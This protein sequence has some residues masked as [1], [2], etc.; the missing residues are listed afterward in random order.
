VRAMSE[1]LLQQF[2]SG[3]LILQGLLQFRPISR[4]HNLMNKSDC[5]PAIR[6]FDAL[7]A[8]SH[9]ST[10]LAYRRAW[11]ALQPNARFVSNAR[12]AS[13]PRLVSNARFVSKIRIRA[14]LQRCRNCCKITGAFRRCGSQY[15]LI[16][17]RASAVPLSPTNM[18]L[19][20]SLLHC[21]AI[22]PRTPPANGEVASHRELCSPAV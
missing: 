20:A 18:R 21:P 13:N 2:W 5:N 12:F 15:H 1:S 10:R 11:H 14:S 8:A 17:Q 4:L 19:A 6:P 9:P 16:Q 22:S 3:E 7:E